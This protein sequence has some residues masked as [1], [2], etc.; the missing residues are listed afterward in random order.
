MIELKKLNNG[1]VVALEEIAYVRSISFGIWVKNGSRNETPEENGVSHYIEH[2]MFKGTEKRT[3][4]DIAEEM[5]AVGGQINAY[6]TKEYTCYHTRVLDEHFDRG[7]DVMEDMV[8]HSAFLQKEVDKERNVITEEIYMYEDAPEELVHDALQDAI[9][10]DSSLG[11]PILGTEETIGN[12]TAEHIKA[13]YEANYHTENMVLSVAGNFKTDEMMEKLN[14]KLGSFHRN[15]PYKPYETKAEYKV[16]HVV[17]EKDVEQVHTVLAF[18]CFGRNHKDKY[19]LAVFNTMFG[20]GMSSRLFQKVR[21]EEGLT[22]SIYSYT[23]AFDDTGLFSIYAGMNPNQLER[24]FALVKAEIE[25][26]KAHVLS[27]KWIAVTKE[28]MISNFIIGTESTLNRMNSAGA[29]LLLRGSVDETEEVIA[30][31][32]VVTGDDILRVANTIFDMTQISW[33]AVGNVKNLDVDGIA[34]KIFS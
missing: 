13:Y 34:N 11:M 2:M 24:V 20:G 33:C 31:L 9:W 17:R 12:L 28:Q 5:D 32:S 10:S 7:L 1:I 4:K 30:K 29:A 23:T 14:R 16:S 19:A 26:V 15:Q 18:P 6:T 8:L 27:E 25:E 21:E 3:A 22:Y